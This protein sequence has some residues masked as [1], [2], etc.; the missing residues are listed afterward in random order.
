M[1]Y[2]I[3]LDPLSSNAAKVGNDNRLAVDA[4]TESIEE[5]AITEGDGFNIATGDINLTSTNE[6][7]VFFLKNNETVSLII[8][9]VFLNAFNSV[10]TL[11]GA[12]PTL[13]VYR[14]PTAGTIISGASPATALN[15]NF[16]SANQISANIYQGAEASTI[17]EN[18]GV[19]K[20]PLPTRAALSLVEFSAKVIIPPGFSYGISYQPEAGSTS[21][22][23]IAGVTAIKLPEDF[24]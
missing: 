3:I 12:N 2:T 24:A 20:V 11:T 6:S 13:R 5:K 18:G 15:A 8:T 17:T 22:D 4:V 21:V 23:I 9:S 19:I 14:N 10:G 7:A 1:S 16:G